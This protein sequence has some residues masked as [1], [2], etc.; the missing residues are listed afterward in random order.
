MGEINIYDNR[1]TIFS[2]KEFKYIVSLIVDLKNSFE[3]NKF[4]KSLA[5]Y[6]LMFKD[7]FF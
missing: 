6:Q 5:Q 7:V 3:K 1:K 2:L 4:F